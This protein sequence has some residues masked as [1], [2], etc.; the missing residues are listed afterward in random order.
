MKRKKAAALKYN[1]AYGVP[2]VTA[3]GFGQVADK[4]LQ[5]ASQNDVPIIENSELIE[6][7][8]SVPVGQNIPPELYEAVAEIIAFIYRINDEKL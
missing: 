8:S 1:K 2:V 7:L 5:S 3:I 6:T 4:I